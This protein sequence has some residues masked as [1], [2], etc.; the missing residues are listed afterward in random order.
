[1]IPVKEWI[2]YV[3]I[4][5]TL[6]GLIFLYSAE[7][8]ELL[9]IFNDG[10]LQRMR[11]AGTTGVGVKHLA[12]QDSRVLALF[13]SG[14]QAE[15]AAWAVAAVCDLSTIRVYSPNSEHREAFVRR[16]GDTLSIEVKA[17][18]SPEAAV[19]GAD[20]VAAATNA[21]R[22]P[23]VRTDLI[24]PGMHLTSVRPT[25]E[26]D[27]EAWGRSSLIV[28]SSLPGYY[29]SQRTENQA[30][31]GIS[32]DAEQRAGEERR[33]QILRDKIHS[34]SDVLV[35]RFPGRTAPE[36]VTLMNK[37]WGLGIE[38]ASVGKLAYD[39]AKAKGVGK[40]VPT[41]WFSQ[42]SHP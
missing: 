12:R 25:G 6:V 34:L 24:E 26:F 19:K 27:E 14:W 33:L 1:M 37:N 9:A 3:I 39:L 30:L 29:F 18:D 7:T 35:G 11:V 36:Q 17:V 2:L 38:F 31:E 4:S 8:L 10:H 21:S 23:V 16:L 28:F 32:S 22:G 13:G 40:E 41:E 42:T 15:T 5:I 20:I